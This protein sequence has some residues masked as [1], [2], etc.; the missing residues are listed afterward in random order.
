MAGNV[1]LMLAMNLAL[2]FATVL[3]VKQK[4]PAD[5]VSRGSFNGMLTELPDKSGSKVNYLHPPAQPAPT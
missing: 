4:T 1:A 5:I 2:P 3:F